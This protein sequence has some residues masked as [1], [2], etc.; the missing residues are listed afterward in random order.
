MAIVLRFI[1]WH[2][3]YCLCWMSVC[4]CIIICRVQCAHSLRF[5]SWSRHWTQARRSCSRCC[6]TRPSICSSRR[7]NARWTP[8]AASSNSPRRTS[9]LG[10]SRPTGIDRYLFTVSVGMCR[11]LVYWLPACMGRL[12]RDGRCCGREAQSGRRTKINWT[13]TAR[14]TLAC[15]ISNCSTVAV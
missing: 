8:A 12:R 13:K 7:W 14:R 4:L 5:R 6:L 3:V 15:V 2:S 10:S 1:Q 9:P 11:S